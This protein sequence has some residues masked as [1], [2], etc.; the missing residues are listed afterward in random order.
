MHQ[1]RTI[2]SL[3]LAPEIKQAGSRFKLFPFVTYYDLQGLTYHD[4]LCLSTML[5]Y[6]PI[7]HR[8][9]PQKLSRLS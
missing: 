9:Q 2:A 5:T 3:N 7:Y 1:V 6:W 4:L 8:P